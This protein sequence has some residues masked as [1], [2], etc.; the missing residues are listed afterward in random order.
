MSTRAGFIAAGVSSVLAAVGASVAAQPPRGDRAVFVDYGCY[1]CH[2]YEGQGGEALRIAPSPY[3][4]EAFAERVRRP[5][6][7]MPAYAREV[8][9]DANL[10]AIYRYLRSRAEPSA[11]ASAR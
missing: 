1:Q 7:E 5:V 9:S 3:P 10:A 6:N 4:F 2:G 11:E 8:L